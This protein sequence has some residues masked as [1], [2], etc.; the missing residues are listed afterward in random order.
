VFD[1]ALAVARERGVFWTPTLSLFDR[2]AHDLD[3]A[4]IDDRRP[5]GLVSETVLRSAR[6]WARQQSA[7]APDAP[8][9]PWERTVELAGRAH[10][11][12]V[13]LS[14]GTDAGSIAVFHGLAVHRELELLV[15]AGLTPIEALAAATTAA[16]AKVGV[17]ERLGTV[18]VG[19]WADLLILRE[20]P[21]DDI[22]NTRAIDMVIKRGTPFDPAELR[23]E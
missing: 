12:G 18:Q 9:P 22:R 3:P 13:R 8:A 7:A 2:M 19:K 21:V 11:A 23:V 4:Y 5:D 10:R 14:L 16:A 15:R 1:R 6:A 20:N 17:D